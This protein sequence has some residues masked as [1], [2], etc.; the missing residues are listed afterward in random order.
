[1]RKREE[2]V[3]REAGSTQR[4]M[5][6]VPSVAEIKSRMNETNEEPSEAWRELCISRRLCV[7]C[8][9]RGKNYGCTN[10]KSSHAKQFVLRSGTCEEFSHEV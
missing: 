4:N 7:V 3:T 2:S 9:H 8:A 6:G 10:P 5:Q 1:M